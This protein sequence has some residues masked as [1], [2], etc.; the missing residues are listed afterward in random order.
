MIAPL[1]W[2]EPAAPVAPTDA[3]VSGLKSAVMKLA[4]LRAEVTMRDEKV[5]AAK[6]EALKSLAD[7]IQRLESAKRAVEAADSEVR[8]L[9]Q[10]ER[11][12]TKE[13]KVCAGVEVQD[14]EEYSIIDK[15]AAMAWAKASTV[16]YVPETFNES[17]ILGV[18]KSGTV[19]PFVK[20]E[21]VY[22]VKIAT[23]LIKAL[24]MP[25]PSVGAEG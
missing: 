9:A 16:G 12:R 3:P 8:A 11:E 17:A 5:K 14:G 15:A 21:T 18:A 13:K 25:A 24:E 19:L 20:K 6:V 2:E 10:L 7:D 22:K 1:T 23:D 4:V